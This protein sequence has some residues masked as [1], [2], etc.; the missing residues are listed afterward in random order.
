MNVLKL[1]MFV[2]ILGTT[3]C[4]LS[5]LR[6]VANKPDALDLHIDASCYAPCTEQ[7]AAVTADPDS[8]VLAAITEHEYRKQCELRRLACTQALKRGIDA[9]VIK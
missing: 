7:S 1:G 4:G 2:L 5:H 9:G 3:G 6:I 8:A